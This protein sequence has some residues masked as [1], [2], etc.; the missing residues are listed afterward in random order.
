MQFDANICLN[1]PWLVFLGFAPSQAHTMGRWG[2]EFRELIK[3]VVTKMTS[4]CIF[5]NK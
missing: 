4:C 2:N 3:E 5:R 1:G